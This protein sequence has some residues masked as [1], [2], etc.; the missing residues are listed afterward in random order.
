MTILEVNNL[1]KFY[2]KKLALDNLSFSLQKGEVLGIIG[3]NGAGKTTFFNILLSLIRPSSG[4]YTLL[5]HRS[6]ESVKKRVGVSLEDYGFYPYLSGWDNLK[7][8][9]NNKGVRPA[10]MEQALRQVE[11]WEAKDIEVQKYSFGMTKRLS[12][13]CALI[14]NP[15][16]IILDEPTNGLD[17]LGIRKIRN[18]VLSLKAQGK[19]IIIANHLLGEVEKV[20][21]R[22]LLLQEGKTIDLLE[23][24]NIGLQKCQQWEVKDAQAAYLQLD[25]V[26]GIRVMDV[27]I[28]TIV[29]TS[30]DPETTLFLHKDFLAQGAFL[31]DGIERKVTLEDIFYASLLNKT[32]PTHTTSPQPSTHAPA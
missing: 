29:F 13:A 21:D 5:G 3:P 12:I 19:T 11:L 27:D 10:E 8:T 30:D 6:I 24:R 17:P 14:G 20:C 2:G 1:T 26:P 16:F 4:S 22:I 23:T 25:T 32:K 28:N 31:A 9:A 7:I 18:L 15:E